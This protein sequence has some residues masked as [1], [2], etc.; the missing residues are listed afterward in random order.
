METTQNKIVILGIHDGHNAGA[1]LVVDGKVIA[2][3]NEE[4]LNN[5][6]N[7]SGVPKLAIKKV[8]EISGISPRDVTLITIAS[9]LRLDN[10][11]KVEKNTV[12][13]LAEIFSPWFH[14][15]WLSHS[16]VALFHLF[17]KKEELINQLEM[18]GM[19]GKPIQF[20]EHH[21]VHAAC[22]FYQRPWSEKTLI[23]TLDGMGDSISATVSIGSQF[24]MKR[25][26]ETSYYDSIGNNLYSEITAY[27]GMKRWEHEY[28][29]MGLA[30]YGKSTG[31]I[32]D[33][34][35][36]VRINP[37]NPLEFENISGHYLKKMQK[38]YQKMLR[39]KRF[40]NIAAATQ[41]YFQELVVNW[42]KN[43]IKETKIHKIVCAGGSFLNVKTNKLIRELPEVESFFVYPAA[44]DGGAPVGV[45]LEG[46]YRYC[47][48]NKLTAKK[49]IIDSLY[50]GHQYTEEEI[51]DFISSKKLKK[52]PRKVSAKEVSSYLKNG[53]VIARFAG[54]DEFGPR[55]LGNRS[56]LAD[57]RNLSIIRK[58]NVAIKQRDFWMPF[59]P[60]ILEGD[61]PKYVKKSRFSPY[62][63]EAFDTTEQAKDIIAGLHPFDLTTRPQTVN[64]WNPGLESILKEFKKITGVGGLLNTSFNIHGY[65][66]CGTLQTAYWTFT[67][68]G[69]DGLL[70]EN[71]L[72]EK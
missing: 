17:R 28:K 4:R 30:P 55:A 23:F 35:N 72:I 22:A 6:K 26:A 52:K 40:D 20:I 39:G 18:L 31:I 60:A 7:F 15:K 69:L 56:I 44:E 49:T 61:Q 29:V 13:L 37:G 33:L 21:I 34:R 64:E 2:A 38:V 67:H 42:V 11:V 47:E 50:Y 43:A 68:S 9:L 19:Y 10:P 65:P 46:Y 36:V 16:A 51:T 57:P 32:D 5:E 59:A 8:F 70:L 66:L 53:K 1:A 24:N 27:L 25:I 58:I 45:A 12:H 14:Q 3:I 62:M 54:R 63:I 41:E 48:K 71:W